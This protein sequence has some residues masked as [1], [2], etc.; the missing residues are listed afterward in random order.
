M[1]TAMAD[2][3][4][5]LSEALDGEQRALVEHDVAALVVATGNKLEALRELERDPPLHDAARL[6]E[7]AQRNHAN[8]V[9]LARRRREINWALRQL[10]RSET[11][12]A[13]DAKGQAQTVQA[14]RPLAVA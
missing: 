2:P 14:R 13:Y 6:K 4:Q 7:L 12:A 3:L 9:L 10:G 8:G 5:R 1:T 11:S